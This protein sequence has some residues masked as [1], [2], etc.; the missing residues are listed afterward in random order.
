M[1]FQQ[2]QDTF[3]KLES[4]TTKS[5]FEDLADIFEKLE[6]FTEHVDGYIADNP[7]EE[8]TVRELLKKS[9]RRYSELLGPLLNADNALLE[10]Y[11]RIAKVI[12]LLHQLEF[13]SFTSDQ[14]V[15]LQEEL[16]NIENEYVCD[17]VFVPPE[18]VNNSNPHE[19][20]RKGQAILFG[21]LNH[22][23]RMARLLVEQC[24]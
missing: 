14:V 18:L 13:M 6:Q 2:L 16:V 3:V 17:G 21:L 9:Y 22:A 10:P 5:S 23:H 7:D 19:H 4:I 8:K 15:P 20:V 1:D 24:E 12:H 11:N